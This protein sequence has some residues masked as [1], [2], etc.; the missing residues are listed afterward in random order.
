MSLAQMILTSTRTNRFLHFS[1]RRADT[2]SPFVRLFC[3][4]F[5][6]LFVGSLPCFVLFC[7]VL[8]C[9]ALFSFVRFSFPFGFR[10]NM[11]RRLSVAAISY[12][13]SLVVDE[14]RLESRTS[15]VGWQPSRN[16]K[17]MRKACKPTFVFC[18]VFLCR[19][20]GSIQAI[21]IR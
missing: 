8:F 21:N 6:F 20:N 5:C 19:S 11:V 16:A 17:S 13:S 3:L 7:F 4:A 10:M 2:Q 12:K 1:K 15:E 18:E 14:S 9:F